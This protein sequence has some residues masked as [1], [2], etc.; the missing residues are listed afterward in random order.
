MNP[1]L[2]KDLD[3][4]KVFAAIAVM[5]VATFFL[6]YYF[7]TGNSQAAHGRAPAVASVV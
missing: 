1:G 3:F 2:V 4:K 5:A 7:D 6:Y